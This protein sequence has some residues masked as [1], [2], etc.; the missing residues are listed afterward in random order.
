MNTLKNPNLY[1]GKNKTKNFFEGWYY[2][3]V[4]KDNSRTF[5]FIPGISLGNNA[6]ENHSFIQL[7]D[8][9]NKF[10]HYFKY[11]ETSF[12]TKNN[13]FKVRIDNNSFRMNGISLDIYK[14]SLSLKGYLVFSNIRKWDDSTLNPGSMGFYNYLTFMECYSQVCAING[15]CSGI[16]NYNGEVIDFTGGTV[17]IEKNWGKSFPLEWL[18]VQCNTFND[19]R[20]S[21][22][23]SFGHIPFPIKS[24]KGFL[25]AITVD[26]ILYKFTTLNKS[27]ITMDLSNDVEVIATN[28][29][30]RLTFKTLS[31]TDE[32]IL[33][34]GPKNGE[35]TP[36][37]NESLISTVY[38][39]LEN[40][41]TNE[42]IYEGIGS[43]AG[44]EYGGKLLDI[45]S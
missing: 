27:K 7:L 3:I 19:N 10:Y 17:Y 40:K 25:I 15:T 31:N 22:T 30:L 13:P 12:S 41:T 2:R 9:N 43:N 21:L 1:H 23:C 4:T 28:K 11:N 37:V 24:F 33:C 32:F 44:I 14:D 38:L 5:A 8:G 45:I 39:K 20:C 34:Y 26:D 6:V 16:L 35:M 29:N 18:W 36:Y 42:I